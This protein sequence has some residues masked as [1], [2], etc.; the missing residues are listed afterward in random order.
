M[1][2]ST[3]YDLSTIS[4]YVSWLCTANRLS[5]WASQLCQQSLSSTSKANAMRAGCLIHSKLWPVVDCIREGMVDCIREGKIDKRYNNKACIYVLRAKY[6]F[7]NIISH[8][9]GR[10]CI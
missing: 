1:V 10:W 4:I 7:A 6:L 9:C 2:S 8:G 5:T 3:L